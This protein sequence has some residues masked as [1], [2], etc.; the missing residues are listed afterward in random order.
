MTSVLLGC[1]SG[2]DVYVVNKL[3]EL[4]PIKTELKRP[5]STEYDD[6]LVAKMSAKGKVA[7]GTTRLPVYLSHKEL[8]E[9]YLCQAGKRKFA[10]DMHHALSTSASERERSYTELKRYL[11]SKQPYNQ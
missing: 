3:A 2:K 8:E 6:C 11:E 5:I 9:A 4:Q 10:T 1:Q 7:P